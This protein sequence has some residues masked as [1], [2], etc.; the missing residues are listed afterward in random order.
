MKYECPVCGAK[1]EHERIDDGII[2]NRIKKDGEVVEM[3]NK[4]NGGNY[5][6]CSKN[7]SHDIGQ[8]LVEAVLDLVL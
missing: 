6:Y 3:G 4:S 5:V 1:L 2:V 8:D 7:K